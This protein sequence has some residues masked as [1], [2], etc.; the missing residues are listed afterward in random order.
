MLLIPNQLWIKDVYHPKILISLEEGLVNTNEQLNFVYTNCRSLGNKFLELGQT[1]SRK[2]N[3]V[4]VSETWFNA[5]CERS[6]QGFHSYYCSR[7]LRKGGGVALYIDSSIVCRPQVIETKL[8]DYD[9]DVVIVKLHLCGK[10]L[11]V[12]VFY[13]PP[14]LSI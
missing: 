1:S 9:F 2:A 4:A 14:N 11:Y 8:S 5:G 3:L 13:R 10:N 7:K 12:A 6:I